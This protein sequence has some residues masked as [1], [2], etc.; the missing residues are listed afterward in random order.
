MSLAGGPAARRRLYPY[1]Y[2]LPGLLAMVATT[3]IPAVVTV[4]ISFTNYSLLHLRNWHFIGLRNF[5][6]IL[7]GS[8]RAEFFGVFAWTVTWAV[9]STA[10]AFAAGL[11]LAVLLNNSRVRERK[12]YRTLL[13][14]PWAMPSTI[15]VM[16]WAGL[17]STSFGPV[18]RLLGR[19]GIAP[20]PWLTDPTMA[21][22]AVLLVNLWLSFPFMMTA[23]SGALQGIPAEIYDAARVDGAGTWQVFRRITFPLLRSATLPLVISGFALQFGNFGVVYLL[24]G[25]GPYTNPGSLAG[26]TDLLATWMYKM[27]FASSTLD[28]GLAAA[29]GIMIFLIVGGLTV[30]NSWLTG[31]FREVDE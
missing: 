17:F 3:F 12:L 14:L 31:A 28:Y 2:L 11:G 27:A 13:I 5:A 21:R 7:A 24:T 4:Y 15:T 8:S 10:L 19:A 22:I 9:L 20:V 6:E 29:N 23:C 16:T 1:A 18:N 25:G 30:L 26:A